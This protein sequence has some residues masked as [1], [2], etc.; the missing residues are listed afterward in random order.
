M[1]KLARVPA[2]PLVTIPAGPLPADRYLAHV[3]LARLG[4][5]RQRTMARALADP[6][7]GL[8]GR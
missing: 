5:G 7:R 6:E 2:S 4:P 8:G 1:T 3:Y